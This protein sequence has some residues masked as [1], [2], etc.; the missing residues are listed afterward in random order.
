MPSATQNGLGIEDAKSLPGSGV[1][2][3]CAG[4]DTP[5]TADAMHLLAA[6]Q[7]PDAPG[8]ASETGGIAPGGLEQNAMRI[9]R[10]REAVDGPLRTII[11]EMHRQCVPQG[12]GEGRVDCVDGAD[13]AGF[14]KLADA[15][16]VCGVA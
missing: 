15:M 7:V 5:L 8:K 3:V 11:S 6:R 13:I 9:S 4:A 2:A 12:E 1:M 16:L 14:G 10:S